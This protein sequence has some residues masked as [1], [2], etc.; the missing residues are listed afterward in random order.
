M[1]VIF[2]CVIV[3]QSLLES[4][5]CGPPNWKLAEY[6]LSSIRLFGDQNGE[7]DQECSLLAVRIF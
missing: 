1:R 7:G 4:H 5:D 6:G 3:W 2:L